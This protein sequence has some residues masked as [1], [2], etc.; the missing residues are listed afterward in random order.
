MATAAASAGF[1]SRQPITRASPRAMG[2][3]RARS[4]RAATPA[5]A[6]LSSS[7]TPTLVTSPDDPSQSSAVA[8]GMCT[9]S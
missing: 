4:T 9:S 1:A 8:S 2:S 7:T 6:A 3:S 5:V